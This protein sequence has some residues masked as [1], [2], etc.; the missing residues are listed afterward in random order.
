MLAE[1]GVAATPGTDFDPARGRA[2]V[3]FSYAG[4]TDDM[5][6]ATRRLRAW[7]R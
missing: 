4:T 7:R 1:A 2:Y 3:R 6:E 5:I